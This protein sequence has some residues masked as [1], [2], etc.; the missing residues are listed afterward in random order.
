MAVVPLQD[1]LNLGSDARMNLPGRADGN[2]TWRFLPQQLTGH[3]EWRLLESTTNFGRDPQ[4]YADK[5]TESGGQSAHGD[6]P[7]V[8]EEPPE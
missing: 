2:W 7:I 3:C 4:T 8:L 1:I 5:E 6:K